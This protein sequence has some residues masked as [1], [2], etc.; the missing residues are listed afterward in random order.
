MR[1]PWLRASNRSW[2]VTLEGRKVNLGRDKAAAFRRWH[3][4]ERDGKDG[5]DL[6]FA[7]AVERYLASLETCAE[8]TR[9]VAER[10]LDDFISH[11]GNVKCS[12]LRPHHWADFVAKKAWRPNTARTALNKI[13]ACLNYAVEQGKL[14]AHKFKIPKRDLPRFEAREVLISPEEQAL[15]EAAAPPALRSFLVGLRLSGAR[16][17]EIADARIEHYDPEGIILVRNK[18][19]RST[20]EASRPIYLSGELKALVEGLIGTRKEGHIWLNSRGGPWNRWSLD[21]AFYRLK[22]KLKLRPEVTLYSYRG[23]FV[24]NALE[25][26]VDAITVSDLVGHKTL[27]MI[28]KHYSRLSKTHLKKAA[29][30]ANG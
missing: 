10:H 27:N 6:T 17:G 8:E 20:G 16:P 9:K 19:A 3:E 28:K 4:L 14:D 21:P 23:R 5:A 11:V 29:S 15:C 18:T 25:K 13:L 12:K 22:G 30:V 26:G 7:K 24:T 1:K 2:Y